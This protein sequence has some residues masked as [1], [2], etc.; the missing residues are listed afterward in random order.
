MFSYREQIYIVPTGISIRT[1][2]AIQPTEFWCSGFHLGIDWQTNARHGYVVQEIR[3][4][5]HAARSCADPASGWPSMPVPLPRQ[6][7]IWEAWSIDRLGR[8]SPS[9]VTPLSTSS[10]PVND[11]YWHAVLPHTIGGWVVQGS[12]Y[13]VARLP[14]SAHFRAGGAGQSGILGLS[15]TVNPGPLGPLYMRRYLEFTWEC[16]NP[17]DTNIPGSSDVGPSSLPLGE[18][19]PIPRR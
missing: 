3:T 7:V 2:T 8:C 10:R 1:Y 19:L 12:V 9:G 5:N 16:C 4:V 18:H 17:T 11:N 6:D 14:E 13:W 15:T